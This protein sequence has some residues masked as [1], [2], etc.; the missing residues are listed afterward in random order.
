MIHV[1]RRRAWALARR[2][3]RRTNVGRQSR[4]AL[5]VIAVVLAAWT[6][7]PVLGASWSKPQLVGSADCSSVAATIDST[8]TYHLAAGCNGSIRYSVSQGDGRWT[9][10]VFAHPFE[11]RDIRPQIAIDGNFVYVAYS[12]VDSAAGACDDGIVRLA[13]YY[14][15]RALPDGT[16]SAPKH[17]GR[18]ADEL[19]SLQVAGGTVHA[20]LWNATDG[21]S[22]YETL[23]GTV[24]QRHLIPG[25]GGT[26][27]RVG[28]DGRARIAYP[29]A[30]SIR[31]S[32]FSGSGFWRT[33]V[34]GSSGGS[35]PSLA[36]GEGD[37]AYL[38]WTRRGPFF[39]GSYPGPSPADGTYFATN[40]SGTWVSRRVTTDV[41]AT[42]LAISASTGR[43]YGLLASD[44]ALTYFTRSPAGAW[45]R[46]TLG[47][48]FAASPV[49]RQDPTTGTLLVVYI[50]EYG[51]NVL[52]KR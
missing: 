43:V 52:T 29:L 12:R 45:S 11:L 3:Q 28:S 23:N 8:S 27:L 36:L 39:C 50:T 44:G 40:T 21:R 38:L 33:Q 18:L 16:W 26:S 10:T 9:T 51:V 47:P 49:I 17:I 48:G 15:R 22:Y 37:R 24:S 34:T 25:A 41:G 7:A 46:T 1:A 6:P 4:A 30:G 42:S 14:R 32:L 5:V 2:A 35:A 20:I 31:Y 13:V 19:V